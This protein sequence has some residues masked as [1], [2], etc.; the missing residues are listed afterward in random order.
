MHFLTGI[1]IRSNGV[2]SYT[3]IHRTY[4]PCGLTLDCALPRWSL[5]GRKCDQP[6][7]SPLNT[8]A[9]AG[10]I[11]TFGIGAGM[12]HAVL[13]RGTLK[14]YSPTY[15]VYRR[16]IFDFCFSCYL[17][18]SDGAKAPQHDCWNNL[19][20]GVGNDIGLSSLNF[21]INLP[22]LMKH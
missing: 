19:S 21:C 17:P 1:M 16:R 12:A 2:R 18:H 20:A 14:V 8:F 9:L 10:M 4:L 3:K 15:P 7:C 13:M 22:F 5:N 11:L 6:K